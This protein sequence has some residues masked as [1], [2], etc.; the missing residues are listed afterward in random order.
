MMQIQRLPFAAA[1]LHARVEHG[2]MDRMVR[3]G[4]LMS[5]FR[6][7]SN[8]GPDGRTVCF[9]CATESETDALLDLVHDE[10]ADD[11]RQQVRSF[12]AC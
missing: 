5:V 2:L 8:T 11:T 6:V 1:D 10:L 9:A 7:G 3:P 4:L 12:G